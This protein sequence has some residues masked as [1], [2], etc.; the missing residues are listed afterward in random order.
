MCRLFVLDQR[1]HEAT[2][3]N[4]EQGLGSAPDVPH[5]ANA[6]SCNTEGSGVGVTEEPPVSVRVQQISRV[7]VSGVGNRA[8]EGL[9][10]IVRVTDQELTWEACLIG[11]TLFIEVPD[12]LPI[13]SKER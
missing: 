12:N 10:F 7:W 13:G 1:Q 9:R 11:A 6:S 8:V 4:W 2:V 3:Y 5:A